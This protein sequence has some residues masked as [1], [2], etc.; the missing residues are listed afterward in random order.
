MDGAK[1]S[2]EEVVKGSRKR[3]NERNNERREREEKEEF[4]RQVL[5]SLFR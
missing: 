2:V 1:S 5:I 3:Q 4:K